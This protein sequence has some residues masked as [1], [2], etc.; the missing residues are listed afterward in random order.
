[1]L[2]FC[3]WGHP[4][5]P[6]AS[7][8]T[9]KCRSTCGLILQKTSPSLDLL[10]CIADALGGGEVAELFAPPRNVIKCPH[11]GAVLELKEKQA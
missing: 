1:M 9:G 8:R 7:V 10:K 11:C 3:V 2:S 5:V 6:A 4:P